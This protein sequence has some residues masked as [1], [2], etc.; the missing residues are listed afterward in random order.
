MTLLPLVRHIYRSSVLVENVRGRLV[1][2][3]ATVT[4]VRSE[5]NEAYVISPFWLL[6]LIL[7]H[8]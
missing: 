4:I 3:N 2:K 6:N 7:D 5:K 8:N 1:G